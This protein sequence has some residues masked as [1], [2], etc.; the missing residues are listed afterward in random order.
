MTAARCLRATAAAL[1]AVAAIFAS[2]APRR[3]A[4]FGD[5][6][7]AGPRGD[8]VAGDAAG[9]SGLPVVA[10]GRP[11][12]L[13]E[14]GFD[15]KLDGRVPLDAAF[16]DE[17][18]REV[19]LRDFVGERPLLLQ[20]AYYHCPMLC[21]LVLN[22]LV[23]SLKPLSFDAGK[24]FDVVVVSIDPSET[25]AQ[26]ME[27]KRDALARYGRPGSEGGWHFLVGSPG[28]IRALSDAV[29]FRYAWDEKSQ[30]WAHAAGV[31]LLTADGRIARYFFGAEFSPRD[32]RLGMV[33]AADDRIGTVADQ[34]LL[35]CFH[36]DPMLGRY[37][38]TA[39]NAVRAAG[40]LTVLAIAAFVGW[41]LRRERRATRAAA[42]GAERLAR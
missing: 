11:A 17:T 25:P 1:I 10:S 30:Q 28:S 16:H 12:A 15:Q 35:F 29:G 23:S 3:A 9:G 13:R 22:G 8:G 21:P 14:V 33:E 4:A 31:V 19:R 24:D 34:M 32:L 7:A 39:M 6:P 20:L 5:L 2:P 37:S 40:V 36:Y 27:R 42:P 38:A 41:N 18:G 26:A